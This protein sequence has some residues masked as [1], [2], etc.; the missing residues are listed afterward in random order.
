MSISPYAD[1]TKLGAR[2][3]LEIKFKNGMN[4]S[5]APEGDGFVIRSVW[6]STFGGTGGMGSLGGEDPPIDFE[7]LIQKLNHYRAI[8]S[9]ETIRQLRCE[10]ALKEIGEFS[11]LKD[12]WDSYGGK[13]TTAESVEVAKIMASPPQVVPTPEGGVQFE[14]HK[15][16][17]SIE[18]EIAP[19]GKIT[20]DY[21]R[22]EDK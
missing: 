10:R 3:T 12:N 19:D 17:W 5:V 21:M 11:E 7:E 2:L 13:A 15:G 4:M 16:G 1:G 14:W 20:G 18:V 6:Q 22:R 8:G 9:P